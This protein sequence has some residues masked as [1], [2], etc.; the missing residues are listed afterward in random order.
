MRSFSMML[1]A[2]VSVLYGGQAVA[3]LPPAALVVPQ[4]FQVIGEKNFGGTMLIKATKPN[5][6]FPHHHM[7]VGISLECTWSQNPIGPQIVEIMA[8]APEDPVDTTGGLRDESCGRERHKGGVLSCRKIT[9]P[10]DVGG[11]SELVTYNIGWVGAT[12]TGLVGVSI[13]HV[14]GGKSMAVGWIDSII[15]K[16]LAE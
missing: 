11:G 15:P 8:Q 9:S 5:D 2:L 13:S 4:G 1:L 6:N 14:Y 12:S 3:E 16:L 7:D 10:P